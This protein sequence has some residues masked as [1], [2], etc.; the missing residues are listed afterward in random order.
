MSSRSS[1]ELYLQ[2]LNLKT[3]V[4]LSGRRKLVKISPRLIQ[5]DTRG[6]G[7]SNILRSCFLTY[8]RMV[9][10]RTRII[11]GS[12]TKQWINQ[13]IS[14]REKSLI[15]YGMSLIKQCHL[16]GIRSQRQVYLCISVLLIWKHNIWGQISIIWNIQRLGLCFFLRFREAKRAH[17]LLRI[18][19]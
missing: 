2:F 8:T 6:S 3:A 5:G 4:L 13:S 16:G 12:F 9:T 1:L 17:F 10:L 14:R 18:L 19:I 7:S 15:R 11:G